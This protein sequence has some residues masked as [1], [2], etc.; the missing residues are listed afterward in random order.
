VPDA[1]DR[2]LAAMGGR[3]Q[4]DASQARLGSGFSLRWSLAEDLRAKAP[5][6]AGDLARG[7]LAAFGLT[8][9]QAGE[10]TAWSSEGYVEAYANGPRGR[11]RILLMDGSPGNASELTLGPMYVD[12]RAPDGPGAR[13]EALRIGERA[14]A[15]A[16]T[17]DGRMHAELAFDQGTWMWIIQRGDA[18]VGCSVANRALVDAYTFAIRELGPDCIV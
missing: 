16:G 3:G 8:E 13:A 2:L 4:V 17:D 10:I 12:L 1:D 6:E 18:G 14:L 9:A 11:V 5:E 15:C 7:A